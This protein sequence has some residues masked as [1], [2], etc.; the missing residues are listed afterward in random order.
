MFTR[1]QKRSPVD[2]GSEFKR[3][4]G[5]QSSPALLLVAVAQALRGVG[6]IVGRASILLHYYEDLIVGGLIGFHGRLMPLQLE[7]RRRRVDGGDALGGGAAVRPA[8][9]GVR[10]QR[11]A[12]RR[13]R[14]L[15]RHGHRA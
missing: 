4:M 6:L 1:S 8:A 15:W 7:R 9:R 14:R 13:A 10:R 11:E 3:E 12:R 2:L 5:R